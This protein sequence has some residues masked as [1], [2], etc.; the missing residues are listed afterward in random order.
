M[1]FIGVKGSG[2]SATLKSLARDYVSLGN[3][4]MILDIESE[5]RTLAEMFGGQVIRLNKNSTLNVLQLR[6]Q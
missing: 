2:K 6:K 1:M 5:Y 3:K 4:I